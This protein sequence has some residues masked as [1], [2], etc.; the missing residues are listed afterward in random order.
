MGICK[1][2]DSMARTEI[3]PPKVSYYAI[4]YFLASSLVRVRFRGLGLVVCL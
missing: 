2:H 4:S 3:I 1:S